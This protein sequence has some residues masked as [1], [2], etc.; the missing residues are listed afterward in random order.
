MRPEAAFVTEQT[1]KLHVHQL[2]MYNIVWCPA[3]VEFYFHTRT[4]IF[5]F[6]SDFDDSTKSNTDLIMV[7]FRISK[8]LYFKNKGKMYI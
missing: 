5:T 8:K 1:I 7:H 3:Q 4:R 2:V 6:Y